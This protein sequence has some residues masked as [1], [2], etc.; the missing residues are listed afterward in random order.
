MLFRSILLPRGVEAFI[1]IIGVW[2][3]G[4]AFV[5]LEEGYPAERVSWIQRDCGCKLVLDYTVWQEIQAYES[6]SG[7]EEVDDHQA[8]FAVYTSGSTGNPK[9]VLHEYGNVDRIAI[10]LGM[11]LP[12]FGLIAPL[13]FVASV[14]AFELTMHS[15]GCLFVIP[16]SMLK[17]PPALVQCFVNNNIT[18]TFCAPSIYHLFCKIPSLRMLLISSEPAYGIWSEDPKL[19]VYNLYAMS[20]SGVIATGA[21]LDAPN[22]T[23]PIGQP[24]FDLTITLRDEDGNAVPKSGH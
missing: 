8:A 3:A 13:N 10:S 22:E 20:E 5:M 4:A 19:E 15:G 21:R 9:G 24:R 7:Y 11:A 2:R 12:R 14:I 18:E 23:A 17:N 6:L 1:A 16:N